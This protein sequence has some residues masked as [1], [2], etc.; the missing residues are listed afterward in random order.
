ME[1][2]SVKLATVTGTNAG[3]S[4]EVPMTPAGT[5]VGPETLGDERSISLVLTPALLNVNSAILV[6]SENSNH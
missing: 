6:F 4:S 2:N 5:P 1:I 3:P